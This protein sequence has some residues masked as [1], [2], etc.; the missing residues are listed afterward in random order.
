MSILQEPEATPKELLEYMVARL[1][2]DWI[3]WEPE[4]LS[5]Y[6]D[7]DSI[8]QSEYNKN[9]INAIKVVLNNDI[10]W[11]DWTVFEKV[12]LALNNV[13]PNFTVVEEVSPAQMAYAIRIAYS[14][15]RFPG[16]NTPGKD[17]SFNS[18]VAYYVATRCYLDG[19][20]YL[21]DPLSFAQSKLNEMTGNNL[22][23][24]KIE[25]A[26]MDPNF[27]VDSED[28]VSVGAIKAKIIK[29]YAYSNN[30]KAIV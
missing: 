26:S 7:W 21:P 1:G 27:N 19:L 10:F 3:Y 13:P 25:E 23:A 11:K 15:R 8:D 4:T 2:K 5:S 12:T 22:L 30:R 6:I 16:M 18:E 29:Y 17:P 9:K 28:P 24:K 14:L 20:L